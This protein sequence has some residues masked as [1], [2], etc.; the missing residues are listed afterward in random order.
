MEPKS[1]EIINR[2]RTAELVY[3][4]LR[5]FLDDSKQDLLNKLSQLYRDPK[6]SSDGVQFIGV[7]AAICALDDLESK[8]KRAIKEKNQVF[9]RTMKNG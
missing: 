5:P 4:Q 1:L 3:D 9:E 2:G 8:I 7:A 6:T